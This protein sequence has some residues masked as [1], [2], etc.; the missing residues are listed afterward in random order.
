MV[1]Q[2][3]HSYHRKGFTFAE[4]LACLAILMVIGYFGFQHLV[5]M[6]DTTELSALTQALLFHLEEAKGNA[7][8]GKGGEDHGIHFAEDSYTLFEGSDYDAEDEANVV[9]EISGG[10]SI[11]TTLSNEAIVFS[12]ITGAAGETAT[13]TI[14]SVRDSSKQKEIVIGTRGDISLV[15]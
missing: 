14:E 12:R 8:T 11:S 13:I 9:Y 1:M 3:D 6:R 2:R 10:M 7:L 15:E 4:V 5:S